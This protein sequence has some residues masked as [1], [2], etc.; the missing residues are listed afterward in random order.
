MFVTKGNIKKIGGGPDQAG[1]F[2]QPK[3]TVN[4]PGDVYEQE[5]DATAEKVMKMPAEKP[6][7]PLFF[8]PASPVKVQPK[9]AHCGKEEEELQRMEDE[10]EEENVVAR[11]PIHDIPVTRKCAESETE[12]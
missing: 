2:F 11:K 1:T 7:A 5:A 9:C 6:E 3:L 12:E 4:E 10:Q 8:K